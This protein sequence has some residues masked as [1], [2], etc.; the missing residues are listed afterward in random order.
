MATYQ[1]SPDRCR[2]LQNFLN[3]DDENQGEDLSERVE[4]FAKMNWAEGIEAM[5]IALTALIRCRDA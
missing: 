1:W 5:L 4:F 3:F 2:N